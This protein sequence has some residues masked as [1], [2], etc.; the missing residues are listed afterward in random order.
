MG[1]CASD[2]RARPD[3]HRGPPPRAQLEATRPEPRASQPPLLVRRPASAFARTIG[4]DAPTDPLRGLSP[5]PPFA[6][7]DRGRRGFGRARVLARLPAALRR[8]LRRCRRASRTSTRRRSRRSSSARWSSSR[9]SASTRSGGATSRS[10]TTCGSCRRSSSRRCCCPPT[11][12][13][14]SR[15]RR[16]RASPA[17][18]RSP[19]RR[20]CSRC[21]SCSCS[22][23][24]AA[25][26]SSRARSTSARCA[27][28]APR[29][30]ARGLL[31]V[32]AGDGGRLVLREILRN[33]ELGLKPVGF[34]DDDPLKRA[35]ADRR[36]QGARHDDASSAASST[37]SSPTRS[38]SRSRRRPASCARTSC[39]PAASAASRSAR[40]RRS[41]SCCRPA[42]TAVRQVREVQVEDILGREPVRMELDRVG[43]YL[44]GEVVLVTGAGG[45]IGKELSR[46]IARVAPRRLDPARPRRGQPL[47]DPAR[48]RARPP[49]APLDPRR[50][51]RGLQGGGA[52][53][54]GLRRPT[55]RRS[56]STPPPTSTSG[57]MEQNPV[58]AVR[59][60][61]IA[62]RLMARI[63]GQAKVKA[64]VLVST[65]KAVAPVVGHGRVEG[66][67]RVRARGRAGALPGDALLRRALRQRARLV[68]LGRADLPPPDRARRPGHGHRRAHDALLH[69]DPRGR[70][71]HHPRRRA[72]EG[73]GPAATA[74]G[75]MEIY[76]LE[77]GEPVKIIDLARTMIELSGLDP[78]RDIASRSSAGGP[79]RSST[80]SSST[81]TSARSRRP[82]RRSCAPSASSARRRPSTSIFDQIGLLVLEGDAA[83]LAAKVSELSAV[84]DSWPSDCAATR[85]CAV[86]NVATSSLRVAP[87]QTRSSSLGVVPRL[88]RDHRPRRPVAA[89]LRASP[90][91]QAPARMGRPLARARRRARP[92]RAVRRA[93]PGRRPAGP[94]AA[95]RCR[96][97]AARRRP[98]RSRPTPRARP[99]PPRPRQ[100]PAARLGAAPVV[101]PPGQLDRPAAG[102]PAC[103]RRALR[104]A[105]RGSPGARLRPPRAGAAGP[106]AAPGSVAGGRSRRRPRRPAPRR[107]PARAPPRPRLR[108]HASPSP[109]PAP[110]PGRPPARRPPPPRG[111]RARR[112]AR[113]R[114]PTARRPGH[115]RVRRRAPRAAARPPPRA[116]ARSRRLVAPVRRRR[117]LARRARGSAL[118]V[119]GAV[120]ACS[121][122]AIVL[123]LLL[124]GGS[125]TPPA[126]NEIG[127]STP[128]PAAPTPASP[129]SSRRRSIARRRRS[130]CSTARRRPASRATS[131][132]SSRSSGFTILSVGDNADQ[133]IAT[134]IDLLRRRQRA[135]GARRRADHGRPV[136]RGAADR[137]EHGRR[138]VAR[139]EGRRR[140]RQRPRAAPVSDHGRA[141]R[142]DEVCSCDTGRLTPR[143]AS[144]L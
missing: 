2:R 142:L 41:S 122:L 61:A 139:C 98:P 1:Q 86:V 111:R 143:A 73:A 107:R 22:R 14:S 26:A 59:N 11:S 8:P 129:S 9:R 138:R 85:I 92:A 6:S 80:R 105:R 106:P 63:A 69:D 30:D 109:T 67:R 37:R 72:V 62:T 42:A 78:E 141:P 75:G 19:P 60:N 77:M 94:G 96:S 93:A 121:S 38:R 102:A 127:G 104:R 108:R 46:Q 74:R 124:T 53:A 49:R 126:D 120:G 65:D 89:V 3:R 97:P 116:R 128:P 140:R 50:R 39:A 79:A 131:A 31:I 112:A 20:A 81:P 133:Q 58:E 16:P 5:A 95:A 40:C 18:R 99:R 27:A 54:R 103:P 70:P 64:F 44:N 43:A 35:P 10:A 47:H 115:A 4:R 34:V 52:H 33:P 134:T 66:A 15:S 71:A 137:H 82:P 114:S 24:S 132:T 29:A 91:G 136:E 83:G 55:A 125:D 21:S 84:P 130:R 7:P 12:R 87:R 17:S 23:S 28:S 100:P 123:V 25:R 76:V 88:R 36:R 56:S 117:A 57:L 113:R 45:S 32:G 118:I 135:R 68:G 90:R 101:G 144:I 110:A 51:P 119:G 13:S 48:A